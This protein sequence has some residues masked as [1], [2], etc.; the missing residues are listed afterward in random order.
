MNPPV[1]SYWL[2]VAY[3]VIYNVNRELL[4]AAGQLASKTKYTNVR[5][6]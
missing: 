1:P 6:V 4:L 5:L 3:V 2:F